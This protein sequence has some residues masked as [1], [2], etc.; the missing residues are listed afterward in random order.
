M[1]DILSTR[2]TVQ[3]FGSAASG[4]SIPGSDWDFFV[5]LHRP[6][7]TVTNNERM[8]ICRRLSSYLAQHGIEYLMQPGQN[9]VRL[10]AGV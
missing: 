2:A 5:H 6:E 3:S 1:T 7:D 8:E 10:Y 9:R 4:T